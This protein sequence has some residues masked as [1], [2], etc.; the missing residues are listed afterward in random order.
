MN[1]RSSPGRAP[2]GLILLAGGLIGN[3]LKWPPSFEVTARGCLPASSLPCDGPADISPSVT[4]QS[5]SSLHT[6]WPVVFLIYSAAFRCLI[7]LTITSVHGWIMGNIMQSLLKWHSEISVLV[8][9]FYVL[10][11]LWR[12]LATFWRD[13]FPPKINNLRIFRKRYG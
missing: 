2:R 7:L 11:H 12:I 10:F 4:R 5:D 9:I 3:L 13:W 6:C 8:Q 1:Q